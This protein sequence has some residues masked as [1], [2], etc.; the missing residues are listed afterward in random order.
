[1][2]AAAELRRAGGA[3]ARELFDLGTPAA[4]EPAAAFNSAYRLSNAAILILDQRELPGRVSILTCREPSEV[5]SAVRLGVVNAGP[6]AGELAAYAIALTTARSSSDDLAGLDQ[7]IGAAANTLRGARRDLRA[8]TAA[9]DRME[10]RFVDVTTAKATDARALGEALRM[11]ADAIATDAQLAHAALGRAGAEEIATPSEEINLLMHA[12][13]G[14]LSCGMVGTGTAILQAL[15]DRGHSVHIWVTEAAPSNEGARLAALQL[16]QL[17]V[18]HS[19]IPDTA[20]SWLLSSRR[21]DGALL[22]AD[23]V[24]E[25]GETL[26]PIGSLN[27]A[28]LA[29]QAGVPVY[30]VAPSSAFAGPEVDPASLLLDLRSP[31]EQGRQPTIEF[32]LNPTTD[33]VP[34]HLVTA[35]ITDTGS[36]PGGRS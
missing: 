3:A 7:V 36:R 32:R 35:F 22:R 20:V 28:L 9:A 18:P 1:M 31:A 6:V 2:G 15:M 29:R 13:M 26:A 14:P 4:S 24:G 23:T 30:V 27:V 12:D 11:E 33:L 17:D 8:L 21:L 25:N 19:V 16:T 10:A 34:H 5:A